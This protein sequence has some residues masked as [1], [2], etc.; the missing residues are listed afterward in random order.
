MKRLIILVLFIGCITTQNL[1]AQNNADYV[2]EQKTNTPK[3]TSTFRD[4]LV[5]GGNFG[6]YFGQS[7]YFQVNPMVGYKINDF[8]ITGVGANYT[9]SQ[10][11]NSQLSMYGTS[12]WTRVL[13]S[14]MFLLHSELEQ[15]R[16]QATDLTMGGTFGA[17]VPVWFVGAGYQQNGASI[18]I[19]YDIIQDP[20]SPY[21]TPVIRVGGLLSMFRN[22]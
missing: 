17:K 13:L 12:V 21:P 14:D 3:L 22:Q 18:M 19:L 5:F 20:L 6:G 7:S 1:C 10:F 2:P 15:L 11:N 9:Y 4:R 16:Y 8:W